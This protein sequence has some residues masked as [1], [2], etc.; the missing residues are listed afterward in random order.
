MWVGESYIVLRRM[1][2][3]RQGIVRND[4]LHQQQFRR[5]KHPHFLALTEP[6]ALKDRVVKLNHEIVP[7]NITQSA[8]AEID[9]NTSDGLKSIPAG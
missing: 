5:T 3:N 9:R 7:G 6:Q 2:P 8:V 1:H 4:A